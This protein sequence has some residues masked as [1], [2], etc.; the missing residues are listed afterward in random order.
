MRIHQIRFQ[1]LNSLTGEWSIDLSDPAYLSDGIFAITGPTGAGKTTILDAICLALYGRTPRLASVNSNSNEIMSRHTGSCYAE[2]TYETREGQYRC[3]WSQQRARKKPDGNLQAHKHEIV[4]ARTGQVLENKIRDVAARVEEI[5]GMNF[6]QFTRAMLLAQGAFAAFLQASADERAPILESITGTEIYSEIS[7]KVHERSREEKNRL[8]VLQAET[9]GLKLLTASEEEQLQEEL[10]LKITREKE[11]QQQLATMRESLTW[12]E[13]LNELESEIKNID[14]QWQ[15]YLQRQAAFQP[16]QVRLQKARQ[17]SV[18]DVTYANLSNV[19]QLQNDDMTSLIKVRQDLPGLEDALQKAVQAWQETDSKLQ[20]FK[21]LRRS[22]GETAK[23][24]REIDLLIRQLQQQMEEIQSAIAADEL[25]CSDLQT[26]ITEQQKNLQDMLKTLNEIEKYRLDNSH[27][28]GLVANLTGITRSFNQLMDLTAALKNKQAEWQTNEEDLRLLTISQQ[29]IAVACENNRATMEEQYRV[30]KN[31]QDS[32]NVSLQG[33]QLS[34]W[35]KKL[36]D[37]RYEKNRLAELKQILTKISQLDSELVNNRR[38]AEQ[39]EQQQQQ[40]ITKIKAGEEKA[41]NLEREAAHLET[42]A[43]LLN[44][45]HNLEEERSRLEDGKACPLCG[46][47]EHPFASENVPQLDETEQNLQAARQLLKKVVQEVQQEKI[48]LAKMNNRLEHTLKAMLDTEQFRQNETGLLNVVMAELS[49]QLSEEN[50]IAEIESLLLINEQ[51]IN[52]YNEKII[53]METL[54]EGI[55]EL[56]AVYDEAQAVFKQTESQLQ[57]INWQQ[58]QARKDNERLQL[59]YRNIKSE[60]L[61]LQAAVL[62]ELTPYGISELPLDGLPEIIAALRQ[63]KDLWEYNQSESLRLEKDISAAQNELDIKQFRLQTG[64]NAVQSNQIRLDGLREQCQVQREFRFELYADRN[65]DREEER[66]DKEINIAEDNVNQAR[67]YMEELKLHLNHLQEQEKKLC[68]DVQK[69]SLKLQAKE[70]DFIARLQQTGFNEE[71]SYLSACLP[72][73]EQ[74]SLSRQMEQ[75]EKEKTGLQT[76]LADRQGKLQQEKDKQITDQ[77]YEV[78]QVNLPIAEQE[79]NDLQDSIRDN[80]RTL[81]ENDNTRK[82]MQEHLKKI[83]T[84]KEQLHGWQVL[85][86][87]IGSADGKKY[88]NFAQG[89]SFDIMI[90]HANRQLQKMSDRY[91]LVR[92]YD[93]NLELNVIDHYQAGE[94]RSTAN[95]SGGE[96]FLVSLAL[97]L[98]LSNMASHKVS[99]D[100][101]FLDEGFGALDEDTLDT[102]LNT[103]AGLQQDGKLIGVISHVPALKERI[104]TQIQVISQAGGRSILQGPGV[105]RVSS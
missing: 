48:E 37:Y 58:E 85:H 102:A 42:Q 92:S 53:V 49:L 93:Q 103:L 50:T 31:N 12:L 56:S 54:Q 41:A 18:L 2:I 78:L 33:H 84:Q 74:E 17:A 95:L 19:R 11:Q 39:L 1:N 86:D 52:E 104:S 101:L 55:K 9:T 32:L 27:D 40:L 90:N 51:N 26:K 61:N 72:E 100:S 88:R 4:D 14:Q 25:E 80:R 3:H 35:H 83:E 105:L 67:E 20:E 5:T 44:R 89:L 10:Q 22:E 15:E 65:P 75:L 13:K 76:R 43:R 70:K 63:R 71:E 79:L 97:A 59:E 24:V 73:D 82:Q 28:A 46:S 64:E 87:L 60:V 34:W 94:I 77:S 91:R 7:R 81:E 45:I 29:E 6:N 47:I 96:S 38:L 69:R 8:E 57:Q 23:R 21:V 66:L 62:Q 68:D 99:V 98:G 30:L 36:D 16:D